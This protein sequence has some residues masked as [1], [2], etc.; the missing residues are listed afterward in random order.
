MTSL[1]GA[2]QK[3][4]GDF[5]CRWTKVESLLGL[6]KMED[7]AKVYFNGKIMNKYGFPEAFDGVKYYN[8]IDSPAYQSELAMQRISQKKN[9]GNSAEKK[10]RE[11][12]KR[13][14]EFAE[15]MRKMDEECK[16]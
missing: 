9:I 13:R 3:I 12:A 7:G 15:F 11:L 6:P 2:P 4:G 8:L 5:S 16:E 10:E 1:E 14:A